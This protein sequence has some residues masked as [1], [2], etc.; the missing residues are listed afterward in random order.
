[1]Y[2]DLGINICNATVF[3]GNYAFNFSCILRSLDDVMK[4]GSKSKGKTGLLKCPFTTE[5]KK[6]YVQRTPGFIKSAGPSR[7]S[8]GLFKKF[9]F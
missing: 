8:Q 9:Q 5:L 4:L 1:M 6:K 2:K 7:H 3:H